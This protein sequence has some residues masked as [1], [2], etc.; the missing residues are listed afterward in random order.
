MTDAERYRNMRERMVCINCGEYA[1]ERANCRICAAK[2]VQYSGKVRRM[3]RSIGLCP[4][5]GKARDSK[6]INCQAC[7]SRLREKAK[8]RRAGD[9]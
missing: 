1:G 5:C 7:R 4:C 2:R 3:R 9:A 8:K 6:W